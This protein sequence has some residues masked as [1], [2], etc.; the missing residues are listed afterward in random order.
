M[1]TV[2]RLQVTVVAPEQLPWEAAAETNV[3]C[4]GSGSLTVVA[5]EYWARAFLTVSV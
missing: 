2:P 1:A 5:V 4:E 3:T